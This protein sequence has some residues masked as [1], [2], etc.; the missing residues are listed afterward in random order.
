MRARRL[1]QLLH[2]EAGDAG[3]QRPS[4]GT[5]LSASVQADVRE[6]TFWLM[7]GNVVFDSTRQ[8]QS[9]ADDR[10]DEGWRLLVAL[11]PARS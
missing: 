11:L 4:S 9:V 7:L 6:A 3:G 8:L 10:L 5:R 1:A 2:H